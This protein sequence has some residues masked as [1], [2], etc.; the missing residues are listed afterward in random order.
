MLHKLTMN[1]KK[2][3]AFG[4]CLFSIISCEEK[5]PFVPDYEIAVGIVLGSENCKSDPSKNAWLVQLPGPNAGN[6]I[7]GDNIIYNNI[8]YSNVVKIF[9]LP[10][11]SKAPSKR[12]LFEFYF[13]GRSSS[14]SCDAPNPV[15]FNI[16][17]IRLKEL[18][19]VA[20]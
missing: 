16:T 17:S 9:S 10:D 19:R 12:Y 11:S 18:G 7:Y 2:V 3:W 8:A 20:K 6:K 15:N 4:I 13:Q 14:G 5:L 1:N